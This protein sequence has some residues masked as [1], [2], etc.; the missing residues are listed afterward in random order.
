[1][2]RA[3]S[4]Q[5]GQAIDRPKFAHWL[6]AL[7]PPDAM[8][9]HHAMPVY[10]LTT[11][12]KPMPSDILYGSTASA[13]G[14]MLSGQGH[15]SQSGNRAYP[16]PHLTQCWGE[17]GLASIHPTSCLHAG[18]Q[19]MLTR[20]AA[21]DPECP[22]SPNRRGLRRAKKCN[23]V[24]NLLDPVGHRTHVVTYK[25]D[26]GDHCLS[27]FTLQSPCLIQRERPWE[28]PV[29]ITS[30]RR[31]VAVSPFDGTTQSPSAQSVWAR[32]PVSPP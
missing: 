14:S 17:G 26:R 13:R 19:V 12:T 6:R 4:C 22:R 8:P 11:Y 24:G 5:Q 1:M 25:V 10:Y 27:L 20:E 7:N 2:G 30:T 23:V 28:I 21:V 15:C 18:T 32:S 3:Q 9:C 29:C 16:N 31:L